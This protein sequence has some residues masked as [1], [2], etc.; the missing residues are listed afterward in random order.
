E[1]AELAGDPVARREVMARLATLQSQVE[2]E[3]HRAFDSATW[4]RKFA[5]PKSCR[6]SDLNS[7][8][9]DLAD[10][11]F[12]ETPHV[13]NEL[14][15]RQEPSGRAV[16]AQNILLGRMVLGEGE[17]RLGIE[18]FP[19]EGGLFVSI[20]EA[21]NLYIKTREGHRFASPRRDDDPG[22]LFPI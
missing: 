14:L 13:P 4:Y 17:P 16:A 5:E 9:S 11:R 10:S 22:H 2:T 7:L 3:L 20:L 1:R 15:N 19:A 12:K 18:G 21:P 6:Q 8:A